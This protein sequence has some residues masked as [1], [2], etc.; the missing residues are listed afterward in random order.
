MN[1]TYILNENGE[2]VAENDMSV[3]GEFMGDDDRRRV[4]ITEI[5]GTEISTVFTGID[6]TLGDGPPLLWE[7]MIF[8][9][10]HD[11]FQ[12]RY[13]SMNAAIAGH[14]TAFAMVSRGFLHRN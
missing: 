5:N 13:T 2:P 10:E 7:T 4:A 11:S 6:S 1:T 14:A 3:W 8:G 9:G 12:E